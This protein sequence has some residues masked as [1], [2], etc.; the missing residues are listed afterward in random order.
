MNCLNLLIESNCLPK[1][2]NYLSARRGAINRK[3]LFLSG[4]MPCSEKCKNLVR[5]ACS[6]RTCLVF[7]NDESEKSALTG[8]NTNSQQT[9]VIQVILKFKL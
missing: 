8:I 7:E 6:E 2:R 9:S 4:Y 1:T 3:T 5:Q